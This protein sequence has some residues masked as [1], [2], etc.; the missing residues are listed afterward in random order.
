MDGAERMLR[1]TAGRE[2]ECPL[3][4]ADAVRQH[5]NRNG[6]P[7]LHVHKVLLNRA[8]RA[9]GATSGDV[10]WR[11]LYGKPCGMS[12]SASAHVIVP[13][14]RGGATVMDDVFGDDGSD[15]SNKKSQERLG[16]WLGS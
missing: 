14:I 16:S 10:K 9:D 1:V 6:E 12:N 3:R 8:V 4:G 11:A 2:I 7:N 5:D 15:E 13:A